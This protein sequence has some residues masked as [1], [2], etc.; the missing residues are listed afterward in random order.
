M[1]K[2]LRRYHRTGEDLTSFRWTVPLL[3]MVILTVLILP[4]S[5]ATSSGDLDAVAGTSYVDLSWQTIENATQ[6]HVYRGSGSED[7]VL[8]ANVTAPITAYH[9]HGLS[10]GDSFIYYVT[11]ATAGGEVGPSNSVSVT[12]LEGEGRDWLI[13]VISIAISAIALQASVIVLMY[14]FKLKMK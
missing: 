6:Y 5:Q 13:P 7:M 14:L 11:A 1:I 4:S 12:V 3:S 9:D 10:E 8:I 2:F